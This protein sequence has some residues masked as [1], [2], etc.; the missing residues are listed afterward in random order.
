MSRSHYALSVLPLLLML[1]GCD[2]DEVFAG[3]QEKQDF[4][5]T[6]PLASGGRFS[7]ENFNGSVD[8]TGWEKNEVDISG[9]KYA[10]TKAMLDEMKIDVQSSNGAVSIRTI[11]PVEKW[12]ANAGARYNIRVPYKILVE[13]AA[14]TNGSIHLEHLEG[15]ARIRTTNGGVRT[16]SLKGN[17]E[18]NTTNGN[19][20]MFDVTGGAKVTTSNGHI[21]ADNL[22]GE[23]TALQINRRLKE[24]LGDRASILRATEAVLQTLV[25]WRVICEAPDRKRC[26]TGK[27]LITIASKPRT[28]WMLEA[29]ILASGKSLNPNEMS[30][31]TFPFKL[32]NLVEVDFNQQSRLRLAQ[33]GAGLTVATTSP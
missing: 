23:F 2:A 30:N 31:L 14:S 1:T 27:S 13:L 26:F 5:Y 4:H 6:K 3:T 8:I 24:Q 21:N 29:C 12:N 10:K 22:H 7:I 18:I 33:T 19:V 16:R 32:A 20:D 17:L 25:E 15:A 9:T 28:M 11:P